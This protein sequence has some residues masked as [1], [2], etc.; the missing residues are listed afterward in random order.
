[1]NIALDISIEQ[2]H[3]A[4]G[5]LVDQ[6]ALKIIQMNGFFASR[7]EKKNICCNCMFFLV[8]FLK[9]MVIEL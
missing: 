6:I 8:F 7:T 5:V 4:V 1:M 3:L 2:G 9:I